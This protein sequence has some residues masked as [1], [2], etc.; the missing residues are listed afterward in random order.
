MS[1]EDYGF[2]IDDNLVLSAAESTDESENKYSDILTILILIGIII[3][4]FMVSIPFLKNL[5]K[6]PTVQPEK[7]VN[8]N[9]PRKPEGDSK[10]N[11]EPSASNFPEAQE[12]NA[13]PRHDL[14]DGSVCY[15]G[16]ECKSGV[17]R[18]VHPLGVRPY[19]ICQ[20]SE[21]LLPAYH[22]EHY[23]TTF[24]QMF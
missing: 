2:E 1:G 5:V 17:C 12:A 10:E 20:S 6:S 19:G 7:K 21:K 14:P 24:G 15:C 22:S 18:V 16:G 3:I 4:F 13:D 11:F 9:R 23:E 8:R